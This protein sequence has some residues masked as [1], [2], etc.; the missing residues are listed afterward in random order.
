MVDEL[1]EEVVALARASEVVED[2]I[3]LENVGLDGGLGLRPSE[4][5]PPHLLLLLLLLGLDLLL[6]HDLL[7]RLLRF[8][9]RFFVTSEEGTE[10]LCR[11]G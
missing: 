11:V 5:I 10:N 2:V 8:L 9:L 6:D 3:Q 7:D 1:V 4:T